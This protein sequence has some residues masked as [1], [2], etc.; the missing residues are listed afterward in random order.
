MDRNKLKVLKDVGYTVR[1][2]CGFCQHFVGTLSTM[3]GDCRFY[4][5]EHVKHADN[6]RD[7]SVHVMGTCPKF[8][9]S[10]AMRPHLGGFADLVER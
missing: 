6:P 7:L 8:V 1:K 5:Y 2:C 4:A 3:W 10:M 9:E